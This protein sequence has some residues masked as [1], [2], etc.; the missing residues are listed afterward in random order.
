MSGA[1]NAFNCFH[2]NLQLFGNA[3]ASP[4]K[5]NLYNGLANLAEAI[6]ELQS[7]VQQLRQEVHSLRGRTN[8]ALHLTRYKQPRCFPPAGE[9]KRWA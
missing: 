4:E 1:N 6:K 8:P 7:E 2:E 5:Y 3:H 9:L